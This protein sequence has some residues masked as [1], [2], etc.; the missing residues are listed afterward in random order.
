MLEL[1]S[2]RYARQE[3]KN[4]RAHTCGPVCG[5]CGSRHLDVLEG[6]PHIVPLADSGLFTHP[7]P[8]PFTRWAP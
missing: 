5:C 1:A 8:L 6:T 7:A 4:C 2:P 3:C